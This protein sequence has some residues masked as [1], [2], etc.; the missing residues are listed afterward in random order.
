MGWVNIQEVFGTGGGGYHD[1]GCKCNMLLVH[2]VCL[3]FHVGAIWV[4]LALVKFGHSL[5]LVKFGHSCCLHIKIQ[6]F[7]KMHA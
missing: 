3:L 6:F 1:P 5:A 7:L 4:H 2:E